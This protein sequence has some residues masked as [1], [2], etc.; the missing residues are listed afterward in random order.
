[1]NEVEYVFF[2][3]GYDSTAYVLECLIIKK[4]KVQP[5]VIK[6]PFI[7]GDNFKRSSLYHEEVSRQNFYLKFKSKYPTLASNLL[8]EIVYL[9]ET[10]LDQ[11]TLKVGREAYKYGYFGREIT[12]HLYLHQVSKDLKVNNIAAIAT[13]EDKVSEEGKKFL[14][15]YYY[16]TTPAMDYSKD[17]FLSNAKEYGYEEFLYETWSCYH[18][19]PDNTPCEKCGLCRKRIIESRL[20]FPKATLLI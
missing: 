11:A 8:D 14:K 13:K 17:D 5:I 4:L 16:F 19:Q 7:D 12:M 6:V 2:S 20:K 15:K 3:G 18:P 9:N 1:M 10:T